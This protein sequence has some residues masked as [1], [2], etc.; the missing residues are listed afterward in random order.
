MG[1]R[2][3]SIEYLTFINHTECH[4]ISRHN[5]RHPQIHSTIKPNNTAT[6]TAEINNCQC[7]KHY[8]VF[9]ERVESSDEDD[10]VPKSKQS[11]RCDCESD[12]ASSCDWLKKG[13]D[14][15]SIED[16]W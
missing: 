10:E 2:E 5:N 11:C 1:Q 16:R 15:F 3:Q 13:K 6:A 12:N 14:G 4:C 9:Y 7:V 8:K